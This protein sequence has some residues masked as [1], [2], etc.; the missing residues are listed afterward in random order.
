MHSLYK[1]KYQKYKKLSVWPD[2][3]REKNGKKTKKA[4]LSC[5]VLTSKKKYILLAPL[6]ASIQG[7]STTL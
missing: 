1:Y 3:K 4:K 5:P 7:N 6:F 2:W